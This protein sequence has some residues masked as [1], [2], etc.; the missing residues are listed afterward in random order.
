MDFAP[1]SAYSE[2]RYLLKSKEQSMENKRKPKPSPPAS[3]GP[4]V[5]Y[6]PP[7]PGGAMIPP[8]PGMMG[9][10][11]PFPPPGPMMGPPPPM[12]PPT[13]MMGPPPPMIGPLPPGQHPP[14]PHHDPMAFLDSNPEPER[15]SEPAQMQPPAPSY[16]KAVRMELHRRMQ[17]QDHL[18]S[19]GL[20]SHVLE[21]FQDDSDEE[22]EEDL[23]RGKGSE[24]APP[25]DMSYFNAGPSSS[26]NKQG[27]RS[28]H[29]MAEAFSA[30]L[31]AQKK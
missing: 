2:A 15:P 27:F 14:R 3:R 10:P 6:P 25:C 7:R 26:S 13:S 31:Q 9:T 20:N 4:G 17:S 12:G 29:D 18:P 1:P 19:S 23:N 22:E 21:A 11:P 16:S 30:G 5:S 8:P 28:H 24:V